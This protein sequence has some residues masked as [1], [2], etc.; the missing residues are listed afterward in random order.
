MDITQ[1]YVKILAER[2]IAVAVNDEATHD[3]LAAQAEMPISPL[4]IECHK[5]VV[6]LRLQ[7]SPQSPPFV[8]RRSPPYG[9][10]GGF[11]TL[12]Q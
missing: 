9:P 10:R 12:F 2:H 8:P 7:K 11:N 6:L 1:H 3:A 5:V 4:V